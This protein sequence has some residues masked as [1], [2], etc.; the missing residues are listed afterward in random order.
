MSSISGLWSQSEGLWSPGVVADQMKEK[1]ETVYDQIEQRPSK[2]EAKMVDDMFQSVISS[3]NPD[4]VRKMSLI[5]IIFDSL[6][7]FAAYLMWNLEK[8]GFYLYLGAVAFAVIAPIIII[9]GMLGIGMAMAS[10]F[11]SVVMCI[12]Y[13]IHVKHMY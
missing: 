3:T 11:L 8:K 13:G 1:F 9:G 6:T 4:T 2:E 7:L 5:M 10:G 12:L